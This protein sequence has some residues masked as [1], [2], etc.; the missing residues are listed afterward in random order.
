MNTTTKINERFKQSGLKLTQ[1]RLS[2]FT[3]LHELNHPTVEEILQYYQDQSI[4]TSFQ[5][6]YN[7]LEDFER[8][9][10][11]RKIA[12][13]EGSTRYDV[14]LH[15]HCH[16]HDSNTN[17]VNDYN[18]DGLM[19]LIESY[20]KKKNLNLNIESIDVIINAKNS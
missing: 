19:E 2:T 14:H 8:V 18:D 7:N 17:N 4:Q 5:S 1:A 15:N 11:V 10:L 13:S 20:L 6:I 16:I 9:H 12:T 3:A